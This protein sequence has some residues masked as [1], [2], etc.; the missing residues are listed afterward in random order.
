MFH[1][2]TILLFVYYRS[3][4]TYFFKSFNHCFEYKGKCSHII[5][6]NTIFLWLDWF[7]FL[8]HLFNLHFYLLVSWYCFVHQIALYPFHQNFLQM[9][10]RPHLELLFLVLFSFQLSWYFR[11]FSEFRYFFR[12]RQNL[13]MFDGIFTTLFFVLFYLIVYNDN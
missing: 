8:M 6:L 10:I 3:E 11:D 1:I 5:Q 13:L 7:H 9:H 4:V 12:F 2:T